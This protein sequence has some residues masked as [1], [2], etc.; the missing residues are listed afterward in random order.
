MTSRTLANVGLKGFW[1]LGEDGWKDENDLNLLTLSV[2]TQGRALSLQSTTPGTPTAGDI[3]LFSNTHPTQAGKI[4]VYDVATW[5]YI[6]PL[7]GWELYDVAAGYKRRYN[8]TT[9]VQIV[10]G[11]TAVFSG[12]LVKRTTTQALTAATNT[13]VLWDAEEYDDG[14]WHSTSTNTGRMTV[15]SG[16]SKVRLSARVSRSSV[17]DQLVVALLKN[18]VDAIGMPTA[19]TDTSGVDYVSVHSAAVNVVAG[20]YFEVQAYTG[21]AGNI[22]IT[23]WFAIEKVS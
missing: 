4:A 16:V 6:T 20:D 15:P 2:L 9:W 21:V 19:D 17:T 7:T 3:Y 18:G 22:D 14:G 12:A 8:G 10:E 13:V 23:S 1:A 5:K 11:G